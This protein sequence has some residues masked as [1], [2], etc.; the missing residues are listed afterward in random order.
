LSL[1]TG[2]ASQSG[3]IQ[4]KELPPTLV[5]NDLFVEGAEALLP[6]IAAGREPL[7]GGAGAFRGWSVDDLTAF[8]A[9]FDEAG[10]GQHLE[11]FH[12]GLTTDIGTKRQRAGG[13]FTSS[14][15]VVEDAAT[16][17]IAECSKHH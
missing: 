13:G 3:E 11:V 15:Q 6:T 8:A 12:D 4:P 16:G 5:T 10:G 1:A 14:Q 2:S 7:G 17:R 9:G